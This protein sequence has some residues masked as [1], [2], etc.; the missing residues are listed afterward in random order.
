MEK[1]K[2]KIFIYSNRCSHL[3]KRG[4]HVGVV[5]SFVIFVTFLIFVYS[6]MQ[7]ATRIQKD[8]E[9]LL[10]Y[11]R[12]ELIERFSANLTS[13]TI[14]INGDIPNK[15]I[16]LKNLTEETG[17]DSRLIVKNESGDI[18]QANISESD[19]RD[20]LIDRVAD[21]K[22]F[23]LYHSEEFD[24]LGEVITSCRSLQKEEGDYM[25]GLIRKDKYIFEKKIIELINEYETDYENLKD[26]LN[27]AP[28][29]EFGFSFTY[30]NET[31]IGT[32]GKKISTNVYSKE[33]PIQYIDENKNILSGFI[34]INV[35]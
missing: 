33:I 23:R 31:M 6:I 26:D 34:T 27:V 18:S 15:C 2:S 9:S 32:G 25:V 20:L 29:T 4:S 8:K 21:E 12:I 13:V 19:N 7:P 24:E 14:T 1:S 10:D 3:N 28:G 35:W 17:I 5:L 11:L 22:F 16:K 30:N